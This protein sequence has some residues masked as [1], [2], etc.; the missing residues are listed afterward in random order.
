MDQHRSTFYI[1]RI[2]KRRK[3]EI[4]NII[5][6]YVAVTLLVLVSAAG[7]AALGLITAVV[8]HE[9]AFHHRAR[10]SGHE[11]IPSYYRHLALGH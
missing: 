1:S 3:E 4:M 9:L 2:Y 10:T 11:S 7:L 8:G 6:T 5:D